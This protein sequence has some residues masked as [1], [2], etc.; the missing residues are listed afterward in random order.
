L[1]S[2]GRTTSVRRRDDFAAARNF[3]L[4]AAAALGSAWAL[5]VALKDGTATSRQVQAVVA[6]LLRQE[7]RE[8]LP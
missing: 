2:R 6:W 5:Y 7:V 8:L 1:N 3:A 4:E